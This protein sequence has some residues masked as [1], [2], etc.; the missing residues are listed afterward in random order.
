M[1]HLYAKTV[2]CG[3]PDTTKWEFATNIQRDSLASHIGHHSRLVYMASVQ[4]EPV[5]KMRMQ[6]LERMV[7]PCGPP[8]ERQT[9]I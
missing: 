1:D 3:H 7:Q 6:M 8:P 9:D 4:N 2:G 5:A